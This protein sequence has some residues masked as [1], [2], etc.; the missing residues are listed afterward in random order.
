MVQNQTIVVSLFVKVGRIC[1][2]NLT[3]VCKTIV[4]WIIYIDILAVA[5]CLKRERDINQ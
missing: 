3:Q 5:S 1:I 4:Q 2:I